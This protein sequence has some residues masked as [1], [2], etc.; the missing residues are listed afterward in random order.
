MP[1][2]AI[3]P[4]KLTQTQRQWRKYNKVMLNLNGKKPPSEGNPL[5]GRTGYFGNANPK[6][7][8]DQTDEEFIK[9]K[10][11]L[12]ESNLADSV[13]QD[14]KVRTAIHEAST[15]PPCASKPKPGEQL[16]C[17]V[18]VEQSKHD[19]FWDKQPGGLEQLQLNKLLAQQYLQQKMHKSKVP[20]P[21]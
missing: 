4:R 7:K 19:F 3:E 2:A 21:D 20:N 9:I 18:L 17:E 1:V 6:S 14:S 12:E 8:R 11:L 15:E 16:D 10:R 5:P 13:F